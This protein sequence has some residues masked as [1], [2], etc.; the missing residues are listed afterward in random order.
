MEKALAAARELEEVK[1]K[2]DEQKKESDEKLRRENE[3]EERL[4]IRPIHG[5]D[6]NPL[7]PKH[8]K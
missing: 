2:L 7:K 5:Q 8:D 3:G 1:K 6:I 4:G